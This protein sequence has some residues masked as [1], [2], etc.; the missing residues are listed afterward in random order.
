MASKII[1]LTTNDFEQGNLLRADSDI[2]KTFSQLKAG[3]NARIRSKALIPIM[4]KREILCSGDLKARY[5]VQEW[6]EEGKFIGAA[7]KDGS[8]I[9]LRYNTAFITFVAYHLTDVNQAFAPS[10]ISAS[11]FTIETRPHE[12]EFEEQNGLIYTTKRNLLTGTIPCSVSGTGTKSSVNTYGWVNEATKMVRGRTLTV[13]MQVDIDNLV[14]D[15]SASG[16]KRILIEPTIVY[17]DGTRTYCSCA[18]T[19]NDSAATLKSTHKRIYKTFTIH[20]KEVVQILQPNLF[21]QNVQSGTVK[22]SE[23]MVTLGSG[24]Y[25]YMP[26]PEEYI[27]YVAEQHDQEAV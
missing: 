7:V 18:I 9:L 2:G 22:I 15:T 1:K 24:E 16:Y 13:S 5:E 17:A 21:I 25:P 12:P 14:F 8:K 19:T 26:A 10:N 23:P 3:A 4:S 11:T 27:N 6:D 20:D